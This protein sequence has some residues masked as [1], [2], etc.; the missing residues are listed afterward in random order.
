[1]SLKAFLKRCLMQY[2]IISTCVTAAIA[3]LGLSID[4]AARFGYEGYFSPL[5]FG[6][7]SLVPSVVTYSR[8]E[9]SFKQMLIRK[10]LHVILLE[11]TLI[12][13]GF[14]AKILHGVADASAFA[15]T[16]FIVAIAVN[17]ISWQFDRKDAGEINQSL[18]SLQGRG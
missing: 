5:I 4:P 15:F 1:M 8:K 13:F 11:V 7:V 17:L 18:K 9:L 6:F 14:W 12:L 10:I 2:F 16:V 3:I